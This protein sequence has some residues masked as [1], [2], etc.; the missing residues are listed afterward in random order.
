MP[1]KALLVSEYGADCDIRLRTS[2]PERFDYTLDYALL[3]HKHYLDVIRQTEYVA[4]SAAW[5]F[6]DFS[7]EARGGAS[8]HFNLKG[9]VTTH[10]L[11]KPTYWFYQSELAADATARK[12]AVGSKPDNAAIRRN[13]VSVRL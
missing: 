5:N 11:P 4:G 3:F 13:G 6:N 12:R 9:L 2:E 10:R 1:D 8:P 7:S